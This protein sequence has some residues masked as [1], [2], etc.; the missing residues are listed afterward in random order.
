MGEV[1]NNTNGKKVR[2]YFL[3]TKFGGLVALLIVL[4]LIFLMAVPVIGV[5]LFAIGIWVLVNSAASSESEVDLATKNALAYLASRADEKLNFYEENEIEPVYAHGYGASPDATLSLTR[6]DFR[7]PGKLKTL[8]SI[9]WPR[10]EADP[11]E[12]YRVGTDG[13]IRSMLVQ[14]TK[15][16]F[17]KDQLYIY[18]GNVDISTGALY[19][20]GTLEIYY[21][22]VTNVGTLETLFKAYNPAKRNFHYFNRNSIIIRGGGLDF[23]G[24]IN[25]FTNESLIEEQF[26]GMKNLI[27]D[28]KM[29]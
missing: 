17:G 8:L 6:N 7:K 28:K 23:I 14:Y 20:E 15:Y 11:V 9:L 25:V 21:K 19:E 18:F 1:K 27:R 4:G 29:S 12:A 16:L 24:S 13:Y 5:I 22:D 26:T 3:Q 2:A 10:N